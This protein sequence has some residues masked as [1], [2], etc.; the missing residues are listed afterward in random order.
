MILLVLGCV[1]VCVC[2]CVW[3]DDVKGQ[4]ISLTATQGL[5]T[6]FFLLQSQDN[7]F[8]RKPMFFHLLGDRLP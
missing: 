6:L 8:P 3:N 5:F 7:V 2:V 1:C 4:R